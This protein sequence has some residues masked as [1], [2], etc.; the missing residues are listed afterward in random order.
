M[1]PIDLLKPYIDKNIKIYFH[2]EHCYSKWWESSDDDYLKYVYTNDKNKVYLDDRCACL[3]IDDE[4][5]GYFTIKEKI[6]TNDISYFNKY[7]RYID[8]LE[9]AITDGNLA[10]KLFDYLLYFTRISGAK[11]LKINIKEDFKNFYTLIEENYI[12]I[13]TEDSYII[14]IEEPIEYDIYKH[15]KVYQDDILSFEDIC[16]L[17][18]IQF[19]IT[20]EEIYRELFIGRISINR[21]NGVITFPSCV[22]CNPD[23]K[24]IFNNNM[25]SLIYFLT[26]KC[27]EIKEFGLKLDY[28]IS[29]I[30]KTFYKLG[31]EK[32][33]I[34]E[35]ISRDEDYLDILM[36]IKE[37]TNFKYIYSL[38][39][40]YSIDNLSYIAA[41]DDIDIDLNITRL[42]SC[43]DIE[44]ASLYAPIKKIQEINEFNEKLNSILTFEI[45]ID[46]K[47][48]SIKLFKIDFI[49]KE[50]IIKYKDG[51]QKIINNINIEYYR[52]ALKNAFFTNW[53]KEYISNNSESLIKYEIVLKFNDDIILFKGINE[54]PKIWKYFIDSIFKEEY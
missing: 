30:D 47:N 12:F 44:N 43:L 4:V 40:N 38:S 9:Y 11:F 18:Q 46:S 27:A 39:M 26:Y 29:N 5:E 34:F 48:I 10:K 21:H 15:M 7:D 45:K 52:L 20:K 23:K 32:L 22:K 19:T 42:K 33:V 41:I 31:N 50:C 6:L 37:E 1:N 24:Y 54:T 25:Y 16:Y 28:R 13:L 53:K 3:Y 36:K 49:N 51:I 2:E 35:D 14:K 17:Q 8:L